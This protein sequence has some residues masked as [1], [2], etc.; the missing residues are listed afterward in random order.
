MSADILDLPEVLE[1]VQNDRGLLVEL[2]DIFLADCPAKI[3]IIKKAALRSDCGAL[4][5]AAHAM[6]GAAGNL[7]AKRLHAAFSAIEQ[8]AK[9]GDLSGLEALLSDLDRQW[10]ELKQYIIRFKEG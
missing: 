7:S 6:K 8:T 2:F 3:D 9:K 5:D 4:R 10:N 1:R